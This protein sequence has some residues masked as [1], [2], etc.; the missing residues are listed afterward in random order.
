M[1]VAPSHGG[2]SSVIVDER[3]PL[4]D[5]GSTPGASTIQHQQHAAAG[6]DGAGE[7]IVYPAGRFDHRYLEKLARI[8]Y[9]ESPEGASHPFVVLLQRIR[10]DVAPGWILIDARAGLGDVSGFLTGGLC[11]FHVLLG[12]LAEGSW[13]GLELILGR[14]GGDRVREDK[15][16]AEMHA[17]GVHGAAI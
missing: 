15:P 10:R 6:R 4:L 12:T 3:K 11:H 7:I 8:D 17:G 13:R 16:Q 14:L 5:T 2:Q 1:L 9:G